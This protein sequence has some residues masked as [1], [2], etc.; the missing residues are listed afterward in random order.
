ESKIFKHK[1][2]LFYSVQ[3]DSVGVPKAYSSLLT[4]GLNRIDARGT[5]G[6]DPRSQKCCS[7]KKRADAKVNSRIDPFHLKKHALQRARQGKGCNQT[8][9]R[10][11]QQQLQSVRKHEGA[12][13][14]RARA[15]REPNTDFTDAFE[16]GIGEQ[17]VKTDSGQQ[18]REPGENRKEETQKTLRTPSL[19][20]PIQHRPRIKDWLIWIDRSRG[21]VNGFAQRGYAH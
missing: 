20:N 4:E 19:T 8:E 13:L 18:Q 7:E 21:I 15:Q 9:H 12:D 3:C 11:D 6:R 16:R 1:Q 17:S 5:A 2:V 14:C 10:T